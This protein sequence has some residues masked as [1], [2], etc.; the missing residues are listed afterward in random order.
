MEKSARRLLVMR[1]GERCDFTFNQQGFLLLLSIDEYFPIY[2]VVL[3]FLMIA[4][5]EKKVNNNN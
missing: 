4:V 1:H 5:D 3:F 2:I